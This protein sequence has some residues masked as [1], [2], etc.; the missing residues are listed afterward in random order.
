MV[1]WEANGSVYDDFRPL[2]VSTPL[3]GRTSDSGHPWIIYNGTWQIYASTPASGVVEGNCAGTTGGSH[4]RCGID[5]GASDVSVE[6]TLEHSTALALGAG[7]MLRRDA[8]GYYLARNDELQKVTTAGTITVLDTYAG[9]LTNAS[10][11]R[12][13]CVGST[14]TVFQDGV[15]VGGATDSTYG[16]TIHGM[17]QRFGGNDT[18]Y[19]FYA[20]NM[21]PP[22]RPSGIL[23]GAIAV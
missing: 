2:A 22:S 11:L 18:S 3:S 23:V 5:F 9:S 12:A 8:S 15:E 4:T 20:F 13:E 7:L 6:V 10:V 21:H 1:A 17:Y 19:Q 14:I 16:G